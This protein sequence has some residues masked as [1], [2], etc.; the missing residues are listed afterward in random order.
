MGNLTFNHP[1]SKIMLPVLV[2][3]FIMM[4]CQTEPEHIEA[5]IPYEQM[6]ATD[7][8]YIRSLWDG[9]FELAA[10]DY[11]LQ[12][13]IRVEGRCFYI[14]CLSGLGSTKT[15]PEDARYLGTTVSPCEAFTT[16]QE[17]LQ[18]NY[19]PEGCEVYR[20]LWVVET[21]DLTKELEMFFIQREPG[22]EY[23]ALM[24]VNSYSRPPYYDEGRWMLEPFTN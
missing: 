3:L 8:R 11:G 14:N 12:E 16:P 20:G 18:T 4:A 23:Y 17:E 21:V 22:S 6:T 15:I 7:A 1:I 19:A 10:G 5:N 2:C 24:F 9:T 13:A